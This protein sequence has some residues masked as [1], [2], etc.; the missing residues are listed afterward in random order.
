MNSSSERIVFVS[1]TPRRR[2]HDLRQS[3]LEIPHKLR[4]A[5]AF[6]LRDHVAVVVVDV[7]CGGS[8]RKPV[9]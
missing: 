9:K 1:D 3:V 4:C 5:G 6:S 8:V 2:C 7:T